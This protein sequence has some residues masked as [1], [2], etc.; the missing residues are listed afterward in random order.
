MSHSWHF[1]FSVILM[2]F[3]FYHFFLFFLDHKVFPLLIFRTFKG[4]LNGLF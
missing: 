4:I 3:E 2:C 1:T